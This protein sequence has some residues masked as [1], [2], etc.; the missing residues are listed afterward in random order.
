MRT[1]SWKRVNERKQE[2]KNTEYL[3]SQFLNC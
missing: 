2:R 3:K 1:K